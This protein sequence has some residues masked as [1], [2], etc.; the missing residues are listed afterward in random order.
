MNIS[1]KTRGSKKVLVAATSCEK[2][3]GEQEY[4][5]SSSQQQL[6]TDVA[7]LAE[8]LQKTAFMSKSEEKM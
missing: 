1:G 3:T 7:N 5:E 4:K 6:Y 2:D 8:Q